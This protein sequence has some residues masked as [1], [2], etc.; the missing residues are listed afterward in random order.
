MDPQ[1]QYRI[2]DMGSSAGLLN[3]SGLDLSELPAN[4]PEAVRSMPSSATL[5]SVNLSRNAFVHLPLDLLCVPLSMVKTIC[6]AEN[7]LGSGR[8]WVSADGQPLVAAALTSLDLSSNRMAGWLVLGELLSNG[9][10]TGLR[11]LAVSRNPALRTVDPLLNQLNQLRVLRLDFC[12]L[13]TVAPL[14]LSALPHLVTLDLSNNPLQTLDDLNLTSGAGKGAGQCLEF[15][16]VENNGLREIP[17]ALAALPRLTSLLI[18][19]NPQ[20]LIG[21]QV[22]QQGSAKVLE[23]MRSRLGI[24]GAGAGAGALVPTLKGSRR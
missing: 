9:N 5:T 10:L 13:Q 18:A 24:Q 20:R 14:D 15:L 22:V 19:G 7:R 11:E 12:G 3:L 2:R 17:L 21:P 8:G 1:L 23:T 4:L 16:S 6:A